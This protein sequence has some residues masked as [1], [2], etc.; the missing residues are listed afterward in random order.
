MANKKMTRVSTDYKEAIKN[1]AWEYSEELT[2]AVNG[3]TVIIP[4]DVK[5]IAVTLVI[6]AGSGKVQTTTD[7]L[8]TVLSGTGVTWVDWDKGLVSLTTQDTVFPVTA[9]RVVNVSGIT[10]LIMRGQ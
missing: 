10:K 1:E 4:E 7:L 8:D 3:D 2:S 9:H 5:N 6:T